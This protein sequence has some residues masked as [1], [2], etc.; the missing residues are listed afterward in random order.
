MGEEE[1]ATKKGRRMIACSGLSAL[2]GVSL[3]IGG[4][5]VVLLFRGFV[6]QMIKAEIPLRAGST[7]TEA[8]I[9][10]PVRPLLKIY[11]FNTTNP[12]GFL[13]GEK[14][15]LQEVGPYIYEEKWDKVEVDWLNDTVT[16]RLRKFY[17]WRQDLSY[18]LQESDLITLP[19]VPMFASVNQMSGAGPL[20]QNALGSMLEILKQEVFNAT[21]VKEVVWGYDHPLIKLGNDVL[22]AEQKLPFDKFGF[23]VNK[24]GSTSAVW[25][26]MTGV[27]DVYNVGQVISFDGK[28]ELDFWESEECNRIHGTDGS[29]FHPDVEKNET[30]FLF[31]KDLCQSLPLEYQEEAVHHGITTYRFVPPAN[32]FGTPSENPR[33]KCFCPE[34]PCPLSGLFNVSKCQFGSPLMLSWPHFFQGDPALV[35]AFEGLNPQ[36]EKHQFQIDILPK[37]GVGMRAAVRSQINLVMKR[38]DTV[39]QLEGIR[40]TIYPIFWFQDGIEELEDPE[41]VS[42]LRTAIHTPEVARS[43]MYPTMLIV[44]S[45]LLIGTIVFLVRRFLLAKSEISRVAVDVSNLPLAHSKP[46]FRSVN[47]RNGAFSYT[48][49]AQLRNGDSGKGLA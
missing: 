7:V 46:A 35:D 18:P 5:L 24:N 17:K 6:D 29:I 1:V 20:V 10:P 44:G 32:V 23:F 30:L 22:P 25:E 34:E 38:V 2:L 11:F 43:V 49:G 9:H 31:N 16:Y 33:N 3:I 12:E 41:T 8:W 26:A 13:R 40:D 27:N 39:K 47:G 28:T 14:A 48:A 15:N 37:M 4:I 45:L 36:Q 19:N 21:S 42:L